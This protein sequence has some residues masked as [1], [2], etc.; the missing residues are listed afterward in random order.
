[1]ANAVARLAGN[2]A[3]IFSDFN[4]PR[5]TA[6]VLHEAVSLWRP[7]TTEG[8]SQPAKPLQCQLDNFFHPPDDVHL[9]DTAMN[10]W[11]RLP[12]RTG[13]GGKAPDIGVV[14]LIGPNGIAACD[15]CRAGVLFQGAN[16]F[17]PWHHHAAEEFYIP[18]SGAATWLAEGSEPAVVAPMK[19][20][21]RHLSWQPHAMRT[22][23][24]PLLALW[25]WTGDLSIGQYN[26]CP[27]PS[28]QENI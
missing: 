9:L 4:L 15:M 22:E 13:G 8:M 16:Y 12:W 7:N 11:R 26:L 2:M 19:K 24:E 1:M 20:L 18:V 6:D 10:N 3:R 28:L 23:G 14:E 25:L 17:Y 27:P 5:N 21:I